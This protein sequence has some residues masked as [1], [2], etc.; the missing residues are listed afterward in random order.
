M[1]VCWWWFDWFV[2][3]CRVVFVRLLVG[4]GD[5]LFACWLGGWFVWVGVGFWGMAG[6]FW[7]SLG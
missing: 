4:F 2:C 3:V 6:L 5:G 7:L 1:M